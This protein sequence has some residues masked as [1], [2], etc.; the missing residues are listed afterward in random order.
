MLGVAKCGVGK[1]GEART[2]L[3]Q[4]PARGEQLI[5]HAFAREIHRGVALDVAVDQREARSRVGVGG[6]VAV[7]GGIREVGFSHRT[8]LLARVSG[9]FHHISVYRISLWEAVCQR[10]AP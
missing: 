3:I 1:F 9:K 8:A 7:R 6:R 2:Q 10:F 4:G 5:E